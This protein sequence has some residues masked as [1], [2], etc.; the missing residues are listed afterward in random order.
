MADSYV[1]S[2]ALMTCTFGMVPCPLVVNPS[3]TVF[4]A[5]LQKANIG[6]FAPITNIASFGMC[7]AP[8]NPTVIAA[9]AAAMGVFT[10][11]PCVPA[12]VS[13]WI[14]G[15]PD[16]LVQGMPALTKTCRNMCMWMGQISFTND[17]QMPTPPPV[18]TP[19][20]GKLSKMPSGKKKALSVDEIGRLSPSDQKLYQQDLAKAQ[21]AGTNEEKM[22]EAWKKTA[23]SY[24]KNGESEKAAMASQKSAD[25]LAAGS[26]KKNTAIGNVNQEYRNKIQ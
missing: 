22:A 9:T 13:P 26:D 11:M 17:G 12:I 19:P 10:P 20:I 24:A 4:M 15:K 6:D 23:D 1:S 14:P 5:G 21:M 16:I 25:A 18:C 3:R 2:N 7:S 8:T